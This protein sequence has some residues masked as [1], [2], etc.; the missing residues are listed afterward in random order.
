[1][2]GVGVLAIRRLV[3]GACHAATCRRA[4]YGCFIGAA[5]VERAGTTIVN[6]VI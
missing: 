3:D 1:M 2:A 5:G 6:Q 4:L